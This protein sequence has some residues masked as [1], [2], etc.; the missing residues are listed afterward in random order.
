MQLLKGEF[1]EKKVLYLLIYY[2]YILKKNA[3]TVTVYIFI[4]YLLLKPS[5][6]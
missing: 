4:R 1:I 6:C 3:F 2:Y 5:I